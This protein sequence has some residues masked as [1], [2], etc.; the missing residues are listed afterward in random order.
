MFVLSSV[1]C[2]LKSVSNVGIAVLVV[3][4]LLCW[5]LVQSTEPGPVD[6]PLEV[7]QEDFNFGN[8]IN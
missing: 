8:V 4:P 7:L 3:L 5:K 6:L 2:H 1:M